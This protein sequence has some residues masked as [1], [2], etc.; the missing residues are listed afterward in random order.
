VILDDGTDLTDKGP[1]CVDGAATSVDPWQDAVRLDLRVDL[2]NLA[3]KIVVR[4]LDS[5]LARVDE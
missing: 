3:D 5:N 4:A 1:V 2:G